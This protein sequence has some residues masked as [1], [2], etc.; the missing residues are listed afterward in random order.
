MAR[1]RRIHIAGLIDPI[2]IEQRSGGTK[3]HSITHFSH[4]P[5]NNH[6][7]HTQPIPLP[8]LCVCLH[9]SAVSVVQC[10]TVVLSVECCSCLRDCQISSKFVWNDGGKKPTNHYQHTLTHSHTTI[11]HHSH[12]STRAHTRHT[13]LQH[14]RH[15]HVHACSSSSPKASGSSAAPSP[16]RRG[17]NVHSRS[18][19]PNR[20]LTTS[21][22]EHINSF[23]NIK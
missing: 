8:S 11:T 22:H 21:E 4:N 2:S 7:Q 13:T 14:T 18:H 15:K 19:S 3:K 5:L 17:R 9:R 6:S 10:A 12:D 1:C 20:L 16:S 23:I